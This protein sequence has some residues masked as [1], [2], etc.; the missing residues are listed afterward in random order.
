MD[1]FFKIFVLDILSIK[2]QN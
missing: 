1:I 2:Q